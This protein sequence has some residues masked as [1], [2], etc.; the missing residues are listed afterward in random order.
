MVV[1]GALRLAGWECG[2][3]QSAPELS[4]CP[5][6]L[7]QPHPRS[8]RYLFPPGLAYSAFVERAAEKPLTSGAP[9]VLNHI[10]VHL[11]K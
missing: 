4:E 3:C 9:D 1:K 10:R 8:R 6:S 2:G 5:R 7:W 11:K